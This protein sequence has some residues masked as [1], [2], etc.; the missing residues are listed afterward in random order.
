MKILITGDRNY[1]N[2]EVVKR[3]FEILAPSCDIKTTTVIHG[4][5]KGADKL[6]GNYAQSLGYQ[7]LV[8]PADWSKYGR[9]AGP[10]RNLEMV[11]E[12]PDIVLIFHDDLKSSKGTKHCVTAILKKIETKIIKKEGALQLEYDYNPILILNGNIITGE[13]LQKFI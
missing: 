10:I 1:C 4:D 5:A 13:E 2:L 8:K 11:A 6:A 9:G 3:T 7:L 12:S